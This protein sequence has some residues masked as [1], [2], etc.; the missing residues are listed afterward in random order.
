MFKT[1]AIPTAGGS[2]KEVSIDFD[3]ALGFEVQR[4]AAGELHQVKVISTSGDMISYGLTDGAE[5]LLA[6][7]EE[8]KRETTSEPTTDTAPDP[9]SSD[10][11][12]TAEPS[13]V[14]PT[15]KVELPKDGSFERCDL[16]P[17]EDV[18][19]TEAPKPPTP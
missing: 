11:L 1:I 7:F 15:P 2:T 5:D 10:S 12:G 14:S 3:K 13:A 18:A 19:K 9:A 17:S 4:N 16:P 8:H 6:A